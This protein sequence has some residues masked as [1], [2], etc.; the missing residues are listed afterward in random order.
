MLLEADEVNIVVLMDSCTSILEAELAAAVSPIM[1]PFVCSRLL[2]FSMSSPSCDL[3]YGVNG[4][5]IPF[6]SSV[7]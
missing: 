7:V 1:L 3:V 5:W 2:P 6:F 4:W